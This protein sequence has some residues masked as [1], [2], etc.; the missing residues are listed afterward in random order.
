MKLRGK[1]IRAEAL[2]KKLEARLKRRGL[3]DPPEPIDLGGVE[4]RVDPAAFYLSALEAHADPTIPLPL[5]THRGGVGR[6][7][8]LAK[9][10]FRKVARVAIVDTLARQRLFNGYTR[11]AL[12]EVFEELRTL[13]ERLALLE[14][15]GVP[16]KKAS[17]KPR[18]RRA[19]G[20]RKPR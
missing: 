16:K 1:D 17:G 11:D 4:P 8:L 13:R 18:T 3:S 15:A 5:H 2:L 7:V 6:G 20:K 12:L 14:A 10:A 19:T 9:Q